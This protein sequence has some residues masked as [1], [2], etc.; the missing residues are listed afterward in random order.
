[1][2]I[3]LVKA[4]PHSIRSRNSLREEEKVPRR[5]SYYFSWQQPLLL[6][7]VASSINLV[8]FGVTVCDNKK[9][10]TIGVTLKIL[11]LYEEGETIPIRRVSKDNKIVDNILRS[12]RVFRC[13]TK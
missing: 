6:H 9:V 8:V 5:R 10:D 11:R 13:Y 12:F 1:M 4:R 7:F 3:G 2:D